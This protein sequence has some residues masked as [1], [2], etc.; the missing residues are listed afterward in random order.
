MSEADKGKTTL[1]EGMKAPATGPAAGYADIPDAPDWVAHAVDELKEI[2][3]WFD[4]QGKKDNGDFLRRSA[5]MLEI[6]AGAYETA[7]RRAL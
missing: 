6:L 7:K 5:N 3:D 4:N 1:T 2:A